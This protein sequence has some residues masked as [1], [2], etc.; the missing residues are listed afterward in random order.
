MGLKHNV[1]SGALIL[2]VVLLIGTCTFLVATYTTGVL[3]SAVSFAS[4]DQIAKLQ[5]CGVSTPEDLF[6]FHADIPNLLLPAIYVGFPSLMVII[7]ML[8]FIAGSH[9]SGGKGDNHETTTTY[10]RGN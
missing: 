2:V 6:K 7:A 10:R 1:V 5:A 9:Y 3:T 4:T 8:M